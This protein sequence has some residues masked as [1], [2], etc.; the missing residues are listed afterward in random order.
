KAKRAPGAQACGASSRK[1]ARHRQANDRGKRPQRTV[2]ERTV[3]VGTAAY[4]CEANQ[5]Y[6]WNETTLPSWHR[7]PGVS[8][9]C[10][11]YA[12]A[13]AGTSSST[14]G[15]RVSVLLLV[16]HRCLSR[17]LSFRKPEIKIAW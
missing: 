9:P 6:L 7:P 17:S 10:C 3:T 15:P 12:D 14:C 13:G 4:A 11:R 16:V 5:L 8:G 2:R 1:A